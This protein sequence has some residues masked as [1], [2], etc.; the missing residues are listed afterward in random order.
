MKDTA[1][2]IGIEDIIRTGGID[3]GYGCG[4]ATGFGDG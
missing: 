3:S 1:G 2:F 4:I